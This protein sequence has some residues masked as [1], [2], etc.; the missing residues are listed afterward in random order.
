ML[1]HTTAYLPATTHHC[2]H[3]SCAAVPL[4]PICHCAAL[5]AL[6]LRRPATAR[7]CSSS[8]SRLLLICCHCTAFT[9]SLP[10]HRLAAVAAT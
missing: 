3:C 6:P 2:Q 7:C 10:R 9:A 4:L 5:V 8:P 1:M